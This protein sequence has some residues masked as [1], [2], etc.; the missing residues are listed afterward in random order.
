[1]PVMGRRAFE[2]GL[3]GCIRLYRWQGH[4]VDAAT[5]IVA[6]IDV[7]PGERAKQIAVSVEID[8]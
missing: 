5:L 2:T 3:C 1:M 8:D 6:V 7:P 4:V